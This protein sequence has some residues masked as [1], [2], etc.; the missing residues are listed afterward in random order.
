MKKPVVGPLSAVTAM[1]LVL[2]GCAQPPASITSS[3][4]SPTPASPARTF[5]ACLVSGVAGFSDKATNQSAKDGLAAAQQELGIS[6]NEVASAKADDFARNL[7]QMVTAGCDLIFGV[8]AEM[9]DALDAAAK[10]NPTV[11]F[12][13]I[14]AAPNQGQPNLKALAFNTD[15]AAFLAG[16]LAAAQSTTGKVGV[17][18]SLFVPATLVYLDGFSQG[19]GYFNKVKSTNVQLLGWDPAT[20][21]G[22]YVQTAKPDDDPQAG[23][24]LAD[25]LISQGADVLMPVAGNSGDGALAAAQASNGKVKVIWTETDGCLSKEASCPVILNSAIKAVDAGVADVVRQAAAGNFSSGVYVGTLKN[26]GVALAGFHQLDGA[27]SPATKAE[28]DK[29]SRDIINGTIKVVSDSAIG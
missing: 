18:V 22:S 25:D 3:S 15:E 6:T 7:Q 14:N 5:K 16:Y 29:I 24:A 9:A 23:R 12:A 8:G 27:V 2:G 20:K 13:L 19:V 28:L 21:T 1:V 11:K 26:N 10:A 17:F 4:P